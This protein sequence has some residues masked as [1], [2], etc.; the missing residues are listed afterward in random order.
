MAGKDFAKLT[1]G[2]KAAIMMFAVGDEYAAKVFAMLDE[3]E[4]RDL[5]QAMATL[6]SVDARTVE[7]L[8]VDFANQISSEIGRAHV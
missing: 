4:I 5:S 2:E 8:F 1:G 6:G 3:E 7:R